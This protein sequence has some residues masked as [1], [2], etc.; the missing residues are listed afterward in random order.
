MVVMCIMVVMCDVY[1]VYHHYLE[2]CVASAAPDHPRTAGH[3]RSGLDVVA[4]AARGALVA[5]ALV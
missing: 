2:I 5:N 3:A 4:E 1:D